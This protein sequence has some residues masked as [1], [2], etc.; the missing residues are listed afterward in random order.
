MK[1]YSLNIPHVGLAQKNTSNIIPTDTI[2]KMS[3]AL[4]IPNGFSKSEDQ[5]GQITYIM[6]GQTP[7][8]A[9]I[10]IM[11]LEKLL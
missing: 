11:Y 7:R 4:K 10:Q 8:D 5:N 9:A 1:I 6:K 3:I 2:K